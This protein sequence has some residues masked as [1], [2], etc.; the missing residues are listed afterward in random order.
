MYYVVVVGKMSA[1]WSC[2]HHVSYTEQS[3]ANVFFST[4]NN[5]WIFESDCE[6]R[7]KKTSEDKINQFHE[8]KFRQKKHYIC[9]NPFFAISKM[10]KNQF[11]NWKK[12]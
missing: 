7:A 2:E 9:K 10:A 6:K 12:V 4:I 5:K 1:K 3:V 8:K 11:L